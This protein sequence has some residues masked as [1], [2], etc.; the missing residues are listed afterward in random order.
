MIPWD[1]TFFLQGCVV[2]AIGVVQVG[3]KAQVNQQALFLSEL[4]FVHLG[5]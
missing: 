4:L 1:D 3:G 2:H 5:F